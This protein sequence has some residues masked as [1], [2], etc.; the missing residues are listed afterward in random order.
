MFVSAEFSQKLNYKN[1]Q[2]NS[3]HNLTA[4]LLYSDFLRLVNTND[5]S[6]KFM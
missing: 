1:K 4:N 3:T 2:K 5:P 6:V